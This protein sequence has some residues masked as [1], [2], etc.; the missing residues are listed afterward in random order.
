[1][2]VRRGIERS[3]RYFGKPVRS[4]GDNIQ[5]IKGDHK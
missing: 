5:T 2:R 3:V 1:M 4:Q